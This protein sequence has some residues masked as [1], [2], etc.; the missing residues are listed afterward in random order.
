MYQTQKLQIRLEWELQDTCD[1]KMNKSIILCTL[2]AAAVTFYTD[3]GT[4]DEVKIEV[5]EKVETDE[6]DAET[7][8]E[9]EIIT[10][11]LISLSLFMRDNPVQLIS[12][13]KGNIIGDSIVECW[14]PNIMNDKQ[15]I[16]NFEYTGSQISIDSI[17]IT[18]GISSFDFR[19]PV[20]LTVSSGDIFK[21]YTVYVHSF[22]G[23]P[24]LWIETEGRADVTSKETYLNASLKLIEDVKTRAAGDITKEA[25]TIRGRGN[26]TWSMPKKPYQIKFNEKTSLIDEPADK[27]WV[28]LANYSDKTM[29]RVSAAFYMGQISNLDYTPRSHFVELILNGQYNGTYLLC[30]KPK[31]AKHRVNVGDDGFLLEVD[32]KAASDDITFKV[33]HLSQP[34][35]IKD[36]DVKIGDEN[37]TYIS[38]HIEMIDSVLY[39]PD[40]T[41][42]GTSWQ[43]YMDMDSFVDWYLINEIAKN[44]DAVLY[45]SCYMNLKR[46]GKLKMGPLWDFDIAFGN[47]NYNDNFIPEGFWIKNASWF[48]RLFKDPAFVAKVKERFDFFYSHRNDIMRDINE[49]AE[50][51]RYAV[52][53]NENKW[54]TLYNYTWPNYNIWGNHQNEIQSMKEWLNTRFEWLKV[55]F[56]KM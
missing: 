14:V 15:L 2:M 37:Y 45:S 25:I 39:S 51:L 21:D 50:Y 5:E 28:L 34:V 33:L 31:I 4:E 41:D 8:E 24:V 6:K 17:P 40:F 52:Q 20:T 56:E 16:A 43:K 1:K 18:S 11:K 22:T 3:Y 35:N 55:E 42:E 29:V 7:K 47:I 10:P 54:H 49:N 46:G 27:T 38:K 13:V 48:S 19:K 26:T 12:D 36:P 30:E 53:E 44:N 32:A 23:L 9:T